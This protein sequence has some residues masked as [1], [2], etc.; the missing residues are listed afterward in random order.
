ME[1]LYEKLWNYSRSDACAFHMPGHKRRAI[2]DIGY[3]IDITE[4]DGFDDLH[5]PEGILKEFQEHMRQIYH[6]GNSYMMVNGS[7][8]GI[9]TAISA[10]TDIGGELLMVRNCHKSAYHAAYLRNL[11]VHYIYPQMAEN[12]GMFATIS[13]ED[14]DKAL[15][16]YPQCKAVMLVSPTYEGVVSDI[17]KIAQVV[18]AHN[19]ILIVDEAHGAHFPF[20]NDFPK[21]AVECGADI[22]IQSTHKT[23]PVMTQ[24][25]VL[26]VNGDAELQKKVEKYLSIYQSSSPSYVLM[27]SIEEGILWMEEHRESEGIRY[28]EQLKELR[29]KIQNLKHIELY[30]PDEEIFDYDSGKLVL[31]VKNSRVG[32][33]FLYRTLLERYHIQLEMRLP[34]YCIAMTSI[35]DESADYERLFRSLQEIDAMI[36]DTIEEEENSAVQKD[37]DAKN[38]VFTAMK[39]EAVYTSYEASLQPAESVSLE[40]AAGRISAETAYVYPPGVPIIVQG[41]RLMEEIVQMLVYYRKQ[42]F[43]IHGM[44]DETACMIQ[45]IYEDV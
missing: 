23:L 41:E 25:A 27:S 29:S 33:E 10:V 21:S 16:N 12:W 7:T 36:E 44:K 18:H 39:T 14:V 37:D 6:S 15:E 38:I 13:P 32:G 22:V 2:I 31:R 1:R 42:G 30:V 11:H 19:G 26:H 20:L 28:R 40:N 35:M 9:L 4:I 34:E 24:T 43:E 5:H 3:E 8:G 17:K 45:V